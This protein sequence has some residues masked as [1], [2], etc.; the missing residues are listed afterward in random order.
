MEFGI[1][2]QGYMPKSRSDRDPNAEHNVLM[3]DLEI[4]KAADKAGFKYLWISEHHFL[5]EYSH[6]SANDVMLGYL[7]HSTDRIHLGSGIFNP[8]RQVNHTAKVAEKVT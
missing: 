6:T 2:L 1:F 8:L 4:A 5:Y 7:A 3:E